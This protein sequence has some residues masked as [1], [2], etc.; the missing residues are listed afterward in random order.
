MHG[1]KVIV[2]L[3]WLKLST[4]MINKNKYSLTDFPI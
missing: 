1:N 2:E 4:L 3:N